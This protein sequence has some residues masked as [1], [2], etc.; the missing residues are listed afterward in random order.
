VSKK[1]FE[2]MLE[3][4]DVL[5]ALLVAPFGY[6]S[7][8]LADGFEFRIDDAPQSKGTGETLLDAVRAAWNARPT[9]H[10]E[11]Q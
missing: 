4:G 9:P 1:T 5:M 2:R 7:R 10:Q 3:E 8:R 11:L 6:T